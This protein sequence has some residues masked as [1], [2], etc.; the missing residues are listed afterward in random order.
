MPRLALS[1]SVI[2]H[3]AAR[4][5]DREGLEQVTLS[6]V[7]ELLKVRSPSLYNHLGGLDVL[8]RELALAGSRELLDRLAR[9][10]A[11]LTRGEAIVALGLAYRAFAKE[12]PG[13]YAA[14]VR[15]VRR[16]ERELSA[17]GEKLV[18]VARAVVESFGLEGEDALH[19]T[20]ALRSLLHGFVALDA[21]GGFGLPPDLDESY[22]RL[23][24]AFAAGLERPPGGRA[25]APPP[26]PKLTP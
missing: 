26:A 19:A 17:L 5:A 11:G 13:L 1:P 7:A 15:A 9:A 8:R 6:R 10:T 20:R 21:L 2:V 18:G 25:G 12:H 3:A 16:R 23:L 22:A 14:T 4:L 24:R